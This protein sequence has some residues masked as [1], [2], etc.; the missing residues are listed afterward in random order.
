MGSLASAVACGGHWLG[1]RA[2]A[3]GG[4]A[5]RKWRRRRTRRAAVC[6]RRSAWPA[7]I[8]GRHGDGQEFHGVILAE[9]LQA[10]GLD[11]YA[12]ADVSALDATLLADF[13]SSCWAKTTLTAGQVT[14]LTGWVTQGGNLI[15][16]RPKTAALR[17]ARASVAQ[18]RSR[19][20]TIPQAHGEPG[21]AGIVTDSIQFH[22]TADPP[23]TLA[24][25]TAVASFNTTPTSSGPPYPAVTLARVGTPGGQAAAFTYDLGAVGRLHAPGQPG[26][27]RP[28]ARRRRRR[29]APTTCSSARPAT[30]A[31]RLGRPRQGRDPAGRRA[32]AAAREPD[33]RDER[34]T[35]S[36]CRASGTSRAARRPS[37]S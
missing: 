18:R 23:H 35:A 30:S 20:R 31:A 8:L 10:E 25:A 37:S 4:R 24:G 27:G 12:T 7:S 19:P 36:R 33:H 1:S 17:L 3:R 28:G 21:G 32:A 29:S 26:L 5:G 13:R 6:G 16:M 15:A 22:G 14:D 2:R 9:I 34:A 11:A